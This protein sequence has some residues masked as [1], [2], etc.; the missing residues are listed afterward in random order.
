LEKFAWIARIAGHNA[1]DHVRVN[2]AMPK[3]AYEL[4]PKAERATM[5]RLLFDETFHP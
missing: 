3:S 1:S 4:T 5:L 2:R